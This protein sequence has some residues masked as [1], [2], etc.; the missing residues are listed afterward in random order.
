MLK[1]EKNVTPSM[2]LSSYATP[3]EILA[4]VTGAIIQP[5][6]VF[7]QFLKGDLNYAANSAFKLYSGS[8]AITASF[9]PGINGSS[10]TNTIVPIT[11]AR[12]VAGEAITIKPDSNNVAGRGT[13]LASSVNAAGTGYAVNDQITTVSGSVVK[14]LTLLPGPGGIATF[15]VLSSSLTNAAASTDAQASTTGAGTGFVLGVTTITPMSSGKLKAT[16][17]YTTLSSKKLG[18][19]PADWELSDA[20]NGLLL[21]TNRVTGEQ[22]TCTMTEFNAGI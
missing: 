2:L 14:V 7:I 22:S 1:V 16:M 19:R 13:I 8:T 6:A 20:G 18:G 3:V 5:F 10:D 17:L 4:A 9:S 21:A 11:V 15:E 12:P